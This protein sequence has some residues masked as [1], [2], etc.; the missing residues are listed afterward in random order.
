M[1]VAES[2]ATDCSF[3][4]LSSSPFCKYATFCLPIHLLDIWA[5]S[6][7]ELMARA[8]MNIPV[9]DFSGLCKGFH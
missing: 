6:S 9:Q 5:V 7:L 1:P 4:V 2:E 3:V 8:A